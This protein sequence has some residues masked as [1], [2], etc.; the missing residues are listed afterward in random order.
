MGVEGGGRGGGTGTPAMSRDAASRLEGVREGW[1][2]APSWRVVRGTPASRLIPYANP[3]VPQMAKAPIQSHQEESSVY[4]ACGESGR[5][6]W[7]ERVRGQQRGDGW[8]EGGETAMAMAREHQR[9]SDC[10]RVDGQE[11][12]AVADDAR[13]H[14]RH[15]RRRRRR[16]WRRR[17]IGGACGE[18]GGGVVV[19]VVVVVVVGR[20]GGV[21]SACAGLENSSGLSAD[22]AS[23]RY[24]SAL[25]AGGVARTC[26]GEGDC[27]GDSRGVGRGRDMARGPRQLAGWERLFTAQTLGGI[28]PKFTREDRLQRLFHGSVVVKCTG[29]PWQRLAKVGH[30]DERG[31]R[32]AVFAALTQTWRGK[33]IL[34]IKAPL[35][36]DWHELAPQKAQAKEHSNDSD[37]TPEEEI[38]VLTSRNNRKEET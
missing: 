11:L 38:T 12:E 3:H 9:N 25:A 7:R 22:F 19:M 16:R 28:P 34:R 23:V 8:R 27:G 5:M 4:S 13:E 30:I 37:Y 17:M 24:R 32:C 31:R 35:T 20:G 36:A 21:T 6:G 15:S 10:D 2:G 26:A 18:G 29:S 14:L 1:A 33:R